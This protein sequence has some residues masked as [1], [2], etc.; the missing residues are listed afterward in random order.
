VSSPII[1]DSVWDFKESHLWVHGYDIHGNMWYSKLILP[2]YLPAISFWKILQLHVK[3]IT[4]KLL[5]RDVP[6]SNLR[7]EVFT[8]LMTVQEKMER[9]GNG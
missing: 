6:M 5:E 1:D 8:D 7:W 3:D 9:E 4:D 2:G